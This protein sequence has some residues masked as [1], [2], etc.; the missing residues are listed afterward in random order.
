M[1]LYLLTSMFPKGLDDGAARIFRQAVGGRRSLA[2]VASDFDQ[3]H[4]RTDRYFHLFL[5]MLKDGGVTFA[6]TQV[7]D[8][9]MTPEAAQ[10][11]VR[12]AEVLW[13][14][15]GD[16]PAEWADWQ[17]Y[18]LPPVLR[19]HDGLLIGMSAGAMNLAKTVVCTPQ[20]GHRQF[21]TYPGLGCVPFTLVPH[22]E[23][24][25]DL[26]HPA[27]AQGGYGLGDD[28]IILYQP[29]SGGQGSRTGFYGPVWQ[30]TPQG[31][32]PVPATMGL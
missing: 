24:P 30:L 25:G 28:G 8:G 18:G 12:T 7:V 20:S 5:Q 23:P 26:A 22:F 14:S 2:F 6:Q 4:A 29:A 21:C 13:L 19:A 17:R 16:T 27:L 9:R 10:E 3:D 11:A 15:G 31:P 1:A 32:R